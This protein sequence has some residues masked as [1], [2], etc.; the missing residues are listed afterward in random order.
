MSGKVIDPTGLPAQDADVQVEEQAT[1]KLYKTTSGD[2]GEYHFLGLP[3]GKYVLTAEHE[4]FRS[5]RQSGITLR[6]G[7]QV[8]VDIRLELG[9]TTQSTNVSAEAPL[10][11][12]SSGSVNFS[13]DEKKVVT[14]PLDGRNFIPLVA[15]SPGVSLP[16]GGSLLPRINGSRPRTNEYIYDGVSALQPE[17]GQVVFYPI[18]DAIEEFRINVNSYS[19]EY[20]RSNGGSV[21]VETKSGSNEFHG[22]LFEFLRNEALNGRNYFAAAGAK[23]EFRRNQYGLT[24]G[25]PIQKNKTFFFVNWQGTRL[26]TGIPRISTVPTLAQRSGLFTKPIYDPA[27]AARLPFPGNRI[28][29]TEFD[30]TAAQVLERYPLPNRAGTANNYIRTGV[31]PDNQDQFDTRLDRYL[32]SAQ[33]V[34]GRFSY[35]RDDDTPVTPLPDGSGAISSGVISQTATRGYQGVAEHSW[36]LSPTMLN[37]ARF[38]YTRRESNGTGP[39]NGGLTV[40]GIPENSFSSA[41]PTFNVTGYQQI[42]PPAG[43]NS[44]FTTSVTEYMDTLSL[45]KGNHT[46]KFGTDLRQ[47]ALDVLQPPNPA[48]SYTFNTTGTNRAGVANSGNAVASLLL[49]QVNAFTIDIQREELRE[50]ANIAEFFAGDDWKVSDKL[51]LDLGTRYTLNFQSHEVDNQGAVFNL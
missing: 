26:R 46:L 4:G 44:R 32:G 34:F 18:I 40:P 51:T 2:E 6:I 35:L 11:Q 19:P 14:L 47:E 29:E 17:P 7:D 1:S 48:G 49:G 21:I 5:Y 45:V 27:T 30:P 24:F 23:P 3:I 16:G 50:R 33:R 42:G 22:T 13:V 36:T 43:A 9:Q 38:G 15:L 39:L 31:E 28:P 12:T 37:Q 41:L 20:G 8:P 10:L 25:G